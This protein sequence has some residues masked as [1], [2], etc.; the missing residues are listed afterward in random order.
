MWVL[1]AYLRVEVLFTFRNTFGG[2]TTFIRA[3]TKGPITK[4]T[5]WADITFPLAIRAAAL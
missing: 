2:E 4:G 5:L 1:I 3:T